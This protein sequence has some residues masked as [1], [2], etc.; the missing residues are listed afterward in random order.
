[1]HSAHMGRKR[2]M[3]SVFSDNPEGTATGW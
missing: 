1:M 3:H 2:E